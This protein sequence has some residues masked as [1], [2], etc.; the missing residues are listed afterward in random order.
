M[1]GR[2][3]QLLSDLADQVSSA[4]SRPRYA[5]DGR[6][7]P[8]RPA[9]LVRT[10]RPRRLRGGPNSRLSSSLCRS[11][12]STD[13]SSHARNSSGAL[14]HHHGDGLSP[15]SCR[16][17]SW[18]PGAAG[19]RHGRPLPVR[20]LQV[21]PLPLLCTTIPPSGPWNSKTRREP[22]NVTLPH[23]DSVLRLDPTLGLSAAGCEV[24]LRHPYGVIPPPSLTTQWRG[25]PEELAVIPPAPSC[26]NG[27][28]GLRRLETGSYGPD[29]WGGGVGLS[30][31]R[32]AGDRAA[33][34]PPH[35]RQCPTATDPGC[36]PR[37]WPPERPW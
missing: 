20:A 13:S 29:N 2:R 1:P 11:S 32:P 4:A 18:L 28:E 9:L 37:G 12:A 8:L 14:V 3:R 17:Q 31:R 5:D 7:I 6:C 34:S 21:P 25:I 19:F 22:S 23:I 35:P 36:G 16:P 27:L 26:G 10:L 30:Q 15:R 33:A 24:N